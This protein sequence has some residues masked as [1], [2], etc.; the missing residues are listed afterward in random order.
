MMPR[1]VPAAAIA[2]TKMRTRTAMNVL[3][4][5]RG[6]NGA[7]FQARVYVKTRMLTVAG[8]TAASASGDL[9]LRADAANRLDSLVL[10]LALCR[11][12]AL[13][14]VAHHLAVDAN[15]SRL[16]AAH[17]V[18][19]DIPHVFHGGRSHLG[20]DGAHSRHDL[21]FAGSLGQV[22]FDQV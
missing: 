12:L 18:L 4:C 22:S 1:E 17:D 15:A 7:V 9:R 5:I 10:H 20:D 14:C 3:R 2:A 6:E 8:I 13:D 19:H 11:Q 16:K 21:V